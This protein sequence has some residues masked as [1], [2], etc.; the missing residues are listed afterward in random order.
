[1]RIRELWNEIQD[2][3]LLGGYEAAKK[4]AVRRIIARYSRGNVNVQNGQLLDEAGLE[5]LRADGDNAMKKL[6]V[7]AAS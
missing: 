2:R 4:D 5:K 7:W 3:V 1:M 6:R